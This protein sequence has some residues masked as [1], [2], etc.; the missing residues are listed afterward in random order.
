[1][2]DIKV[3]N[4]VTLFIGGIE[5]IKQQS[6]SINVIFSHNNFKEIYIINIIITF[7]KIFLNERTWHSANSVNKV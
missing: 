2:A 6:I 4:Q 5:R 1:M 3:L 7:Y